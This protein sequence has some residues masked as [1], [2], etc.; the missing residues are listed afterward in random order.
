MF[1]FVV[2]SPINIALILGAVLF[3]TTM[4]IW[5]ERRL[6]GFFNE[7][8][9]PNRVGPWGAFQSF[10]DVIKLITK[11]DWTPP[12]S[13]KPVFIIAPLIVPIVITPARL[14]RSTTRESESGTKSR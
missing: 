12:F 9:G 4:L 1:E 8:L 14:R 13:D 10:A 7:R 3:V 6:L 11:E 5:I 2:G